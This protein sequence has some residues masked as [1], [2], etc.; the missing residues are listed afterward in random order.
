MPKNTPKKGKITSIIALTMGKY[1]GITGKIWDKKGKKPLLHRNTT[2]KAPYKPIYALNR[3]S[4]TFRNAY[5]PS[6]APFYPILVVKPVLRNSPYLTPS[7]PFEPLLAHLYTFWCIGE[8]H[9]AFC[10][11]FFFKNGQKCVAQK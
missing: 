7:C 5:F 6:L 11:I 9:V 1:R 4:V 8:V 3:P 2:E 10:T